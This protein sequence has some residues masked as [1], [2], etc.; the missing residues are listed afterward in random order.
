[1]RLIRSPSPPARTRHLRLSVV[2]F[3]ALLTITCGPSEAPATHTESAA[4]AQPTPDLTA[5]P[6]LPGSLA[7][8]LLSTTQDLRLVWME[9]T[10]EGHAVR[11]STWCPRGGWRRARTV[12]ASKDLVANWADTPTA[13]QAGD[14][15]T[16][17]T[18][19]LK[20]G[21]GKYAYDVV[22]SRSTD[23]KTWTEIGRPHSDG[24]ETEHGF[25]SLIPTKA[26][27]QIFWLDGR[28]TLDKGPMSLRTTTWEGAFAPS[29]LV[30]ERVC[31]CCGTAAVV[32]GD[33]WRVAY[34]DRTGKEIRDVRVAGATGSVIAGDDAWQMPGCPVNGPR[35]ARVGEALFAAWTTGAGGE[36][37]VRVAVSR[38]G[39][40]FGPTQVL[41]PQADDP[42]GRVDLLVVGEAIYASWLGSEQVHVRRLALE[43]DTVTGGDAVSLGDASASRRTGFPRITRVGERLLAVWTD[44]KAGLVAATRSLAT[45]PAPA[46]PLPP[47]ASPKDAPAVS[48][49]PEL[50]GQTLTGEPWSLSSVKK[51]TLVAL[52][53][54]WC[55]PCRA[56][57]PALSRIA[58]ERDDLTLVVVAVDDKAASVLEAKGKAGGT[59]ALASRSAVREAF[60]SASLPAAWL[61]GA[62]GEVQ[63]HAAGAMDPEGIPRP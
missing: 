34:R 45:V 19:P 26:G 7:P 61:F 38:A 41:A 25:P 47:V 51:R 33:G 59:W 15:S 49:R 24:T 46:G 36:L 6:S 63:W 32:D 16:V 12:A 35:L 31:D 29:S 14:G 27:F 4:E 28:S 44:E 2:V 13:L 40:P 8:Y 37:E 23:G 60:G 58:A 22:L 55:G 5:L 50:D 42:Q 52:W 11:T 10:E 21:K 43:G 54:S 9:P 1:V 62:S 30:D 20:S 48:T 3:A 39:K 18:Y 56:E 57:I 53:A 17:V